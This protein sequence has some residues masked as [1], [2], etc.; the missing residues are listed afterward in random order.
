MTEVSIGVLSYDLKQYYVDFFNRLQSALRYRL[1]VYPVFSSALYNNNFFVYPSR[2]EGEFISLGGE[3]TPEGLPISLNW[4]AALRC[5]W[6]NNVVIL[7]GLQ[8]AT[9]L[10][11]VICAVL[12]RR[13]IISVNQTLPSKAERERRF[14][15][16]YLKK[17]V[18]M[19]CDLNLVQTEA[20]FTT[21]RV[22]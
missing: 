1:R 7:L 12:L 3:H 4:R 18:F 16:R 9:A 21:L 8:G 13:K 20:S 5:A 6:E 19:F 17:F 15:I 10:L 14:W 2:I 11:C 22:S